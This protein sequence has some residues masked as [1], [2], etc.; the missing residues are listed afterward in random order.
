MEVKQGDKSEFDFQVSLAEKIY[1]GLKC[2][3]GTN[4]KAIAINNE[5]G[6]DFHWHIKIV[7]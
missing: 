3:I 5:Q 1:L 2:R 4:W 7:F 6:L